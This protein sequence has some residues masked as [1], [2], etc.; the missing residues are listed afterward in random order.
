M[1]SVDSIRLSSSNGF[2]AIHFRL[3]QLLISVGLILCIV[4]GTS[5]TNSD[6]VYTPQT[7]TKVGIVLYLVGFI[8]L[9]LIALVTAHKLA[10][11]PSDEKRLIAAV[12]IALPFI[13]VR[14]I[15]AAISVFLN[16]HHFNSVT[17]SIVILVVMAILE[18]MVVVTI[19]LAIGWKTDALPPASRGPVASRPWKG[20][21]TGTGGGDCNG[22]R[23]RQ[24]PIHTLVGAAMD[25]AQNRM[26]ESQTGA[27]RGLSSRPGTD[28]TSPV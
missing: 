20:S 11:A 17:G 18:E 25:A 21:L 6:G 26:H 7:T 22:R 9:A 27:H 24:G 23:M 14:L 5:S 4:G 16:N 15:Y 13:L 8:G 12:I 3:L 28:G 1:N 10:N 19:Y 2:Q